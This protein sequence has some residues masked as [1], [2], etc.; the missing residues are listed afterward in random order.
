MVSYLFIRAVSWLHKEKAEVAGSFLQS[1][2]TRSSNI[3]PWSVTPVTFSIASYRKCKR[4]N[5]FS[6][7]YVSAPSKPELEIDGDKHVILQYGGRGVAGYIK[8]CANRNYEWLLFSQRH[9]NV[10]HAVCN[11]YILLLLF[12]LGVTRG[13]NTLKSL[14]FPWNWSKIIFFFFF[15][16]YFII[17]RATYVVCGITIENKENETA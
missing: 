7:D 14:T 10:F 17:L 2:L 16:Y 13:P 8:N 5:P 3:H 12:Q 9:H 6:N 4:G 11:S 1:H 15:F